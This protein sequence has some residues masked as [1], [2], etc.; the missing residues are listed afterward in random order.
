IHQEKLTVFAVPRNIDKND[1]EGRST[2]AQG[3]RSASSLSSISIRPKKSIIGVCVFDAKARSRAFRDILGR[4]AT[5]FE[6]VYFGDK[7]I[8]EEY[9]EN[10]PT[11]DFLISFFSEGFPLE[12]AVAY[13]QLRKPFCVN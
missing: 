3:S 9:V 4:F 1:N 7:A 5:E 2:E 8:L 6:L 11:C 10:W 12:K 13:A